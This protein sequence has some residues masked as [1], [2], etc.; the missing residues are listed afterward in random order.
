VNPSFSRVLGYTS[1]E[2]LS[3]PL[4]DFVHPDDR[5]ATLAA[6]R[7]QTE[8][9]Q[10]I[11]HFRNRYRTKDGAYRWL[12]WTSKPDPKGKALVAVARDV[13]ERTTIEE[14]E[15]EHRLR[16]ERTVEARTRQLR[17]ANQKLEAARRETLHRLALAV[18]YRDDETHQHT[19]RIGRT[20]ALLAQQLGLPETDVR[21]VEEAA[22]LHDIG[23]IAVSDTI[24][25][26]PGKLTATEFE[27]IKRHTLVGASILA[28]GQSPVLQMAEQ[29][30]RAHH[31]WWDGSGY[32]D[33]LSG[34]EIPLPARI[35]A[36]ADVFDALIH[37]RPYKQA[38]PL[39]AAIAEIERLKGS[40]FDPAVVDAF[41]TLSH[42]TLIAPEP[43]QALA[44]AG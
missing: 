8:R 43:T 44:F 10:P 3:L 5:E 33:A 22:T 32:P 41:S 20:A 25:L 28:G 40:Q 14:M 19:I 31:E 39:E 42:V 17:H 7:D 30:A 18:E 34:E 27:Q 38:W 4:L 9:G 24:L 1:E 2:L 37:E 12:E 15:H 35:V 13:T 11:L 29:I 6:I 26:K 16:L 36:V 21:H 23:K